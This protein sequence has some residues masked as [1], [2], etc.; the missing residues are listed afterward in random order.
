MKLQ[1]IISEI[2][3]DNPKKDLIKEKFEAFKK[4]AKNEVESI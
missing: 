4:W 2:N 3:I 1:T